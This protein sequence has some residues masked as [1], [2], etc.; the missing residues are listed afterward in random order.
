MATTKFAPGNPLDIVLASAATSSDLIVSG[1]IV[2][3]A[4]TSG[5]TGDTI[6]LDTDGCHELPKTDDTQTF[7]V[8]AKAYA[9]S[10][11]AITSTASGNKLCGYAVEASANGDAT[12]KVRLI[13]AA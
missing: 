3:I 4:Q 9:T 12:V 6:A 13:P 11:G 2:G 7:A 8:G 5:E 10:A 1:Q